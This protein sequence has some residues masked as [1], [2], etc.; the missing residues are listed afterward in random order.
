MR[1]DVIIVGG[2]FAGLAAGLYLARARRTVTILDTG[3]PR[4][5]VLGA[6]GANIGLFP[7]AKPLFLRG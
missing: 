3:R 4:N 5:R 6:V 1:S 2:S 7:P